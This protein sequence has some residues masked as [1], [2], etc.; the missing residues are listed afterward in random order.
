MSK[1][2]LPAELPAESVVVII[3]PREQC[4]FSM[5]PM[6]TI[7]GTLQSGDYSYR[8]GE[9]ICRIERKSLEDLIACVGRERERFEREIERLLAFPCRALIVEGSW[10]DIERG[11]WR[12]QVHPKAAVNSLLSWTARGLPCVL[13]GNRQL[14]EEYARRIIYMSARHQWRVARSMVEGLAEPAEVEA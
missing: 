8:G 1:P 9:N 5:D 12:S 14:A 10:Q 2:K 11:E 13:P 6:Q 7:E 4:P 3:D